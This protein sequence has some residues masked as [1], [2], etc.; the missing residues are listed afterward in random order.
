MS[1]TY[2]D[3]A[4]VDWEQKYLDLDTGVRM[5]Y[6]E[7]GPK[8]GKTVLLIHGVTDGCVAWAQIA[9]VLEKAGCHCY[10]VE[11]R[12][13]GM[14]D[15]PDMGPFGYTGELLAD[16]IIDFIEKL[17]LQEIHV[18]G[19]SFGSL[20]TQILALKIPQRCADYVLID[21]AVD[22]RNNPV[23]LS[24]RNGDGDGFKGLDHYPDG[25]PDSFLQEWTAMGNESK[26]FRAAALE[27]VR[28]MPMVSWKNLMDGLLQFNSTAFIGDI[29]GDV[30]V[31]WGTEDDIFPKA[32]QDQVKAGL[33]GCNVKYVDVDGA[34]HNGFWDSMVMAETYADHILDFIEKK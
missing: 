1:K 27:H 34:S 22:C 25:L 13:N 21:T 23:I 19:H 18:V 15:K 26:S 17:D 5:A 20:I 8:D 14:T 10:I 29:H 12:G 2:Y 3:Y 9:P 32:D 6:Y 24:V 33:T 4:E 28:Q 16:D 31:L 7:C 11:Y 30:L